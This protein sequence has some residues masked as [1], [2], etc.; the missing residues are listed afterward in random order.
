MAN[1]LLRLQADEVIQRPDEPDV[2]QAQRRYTLTKRGR[3]IARMLPRE[4]RSALDV[5]L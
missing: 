3:R 5:Y 1:G 2:P 4:P